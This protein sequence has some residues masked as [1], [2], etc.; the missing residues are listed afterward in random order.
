MKKGSS[1]INV[2]RGKLICEKDLIQALKDKYINSN[3]VKLLNAWKKN[4]SKW[5]SI[6]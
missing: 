3:Q 5:N 2:S 4:P 1:I 6:Q